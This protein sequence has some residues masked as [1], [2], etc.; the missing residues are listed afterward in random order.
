MPIIDFE[1]EKDN[2]GYEFK[3]TSSKDT[4]RVYY[5]N[6]DDIETLQDLLFRSDISRDDIDLS[7]LT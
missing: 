6:K 1:V 4:M 7:D 2:F 3:F 5:I